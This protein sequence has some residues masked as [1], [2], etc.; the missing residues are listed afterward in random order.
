MKKNIS[1]FSLLELTLVVGLM[2]LSAYLFMN[3]SKQNILMMGNLETVLD[4]FA[5]KELINMNLL[6]RKTC[7]KSLTGKAVNDTVSTINSDTGNKLY[8]VNN[9]VGR[10]IKIKQMTIDLDNIKNLYSLKIIIEKN[11]ILNI[12]QTREFSIPLTVYLD[13]SKKPPT[14]ISCFSDEQKILES[15]QKSCVSLGGTY[16]NSDLIHPCKFCT[17][18]GTCQS[19]IEKINDTQTALENSIEMLNNYRN[20]IE[21]TAANI[22]CTKSNKTFIEGSRYQCQWTKT[23]VVT[24]NDMFK[25]FTECR[26]TEDVKCS[27]LGGFMFG[28]QKYECNQPFTCR[29]TISQGINGM[30]D[31]NDECLNEICQ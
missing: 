3:I 25:C 14:I 21:L 13:N 15:S 31:Q 2:G 11:I 30:I 8:E 5:L 18:S 7:T 6:N 27:S 24:F 9:M 10:K 20:V 29:C 28:P 16:D 23:E 17:P 26:S 1:G 4:E 22:V 19:F 12:T